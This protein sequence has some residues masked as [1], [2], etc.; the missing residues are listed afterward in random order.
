MISANP[1]IRPIT[2]AAASSGMSAAI[3]LPARVIIPFIGFA[4]TT[5][6]P[7]AR[8]PSTQENIKQKKA[9]TAMPGEDRPRSCSGVDLNGHD[10]DGEIN[11]DS[12]FVRD[13]VSTCPGRYNSYAKCIDIRRVVSHVPLADLRAKITIDPLLSVRCPFSTKPAAS[14][15][16]K[17]S[18]SVYALPSG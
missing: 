14:G 17:C 12:A 8:S 7:L 4:A 10:P 5:V 1:G 15:Q 13:M 11:G 2:L 6:R 9:V 3:T 18:L 16:A